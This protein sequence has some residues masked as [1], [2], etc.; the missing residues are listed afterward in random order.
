MDGVPAEVHR[1][2]S[3]LFQV[4]SDLLLCPQQELQFEV[5]T[6]QTPAVVEQ[7]TEFWKHRWNRDNPPAAADWQRMMA[8]VQALCLFANASFSHHSATM[9]PDQWPLQ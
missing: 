5:R 4:N 9:G 1:V 8:F 3:C 2:G 7:L 6:G